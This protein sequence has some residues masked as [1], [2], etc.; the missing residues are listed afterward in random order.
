LLCI[1]LFFH[2]CSR[3]K[4]FVSPARILNHSGKHERA[5]ANIVLEKIV[6]EAQGFR[7]LGIV[8]ERLACSVLSLLAIFGCH[9]LFNQ[10]LVTAMDCAHKNLI[11][12]LGIHR[13]L[14]K[15][16]VLP[17]GGFSGVES[18]PLGFAMFVLAV[19]D[20]DLADAALV[21]AVHFF[22]ER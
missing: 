8:I 18:F 20:L 14:K 12:I 16:V 9:G 6:G 10:N 1:E 17:E 19:R 11:W 21:D 7:R 4:Q 2:P 3:L 22:V 15:F 13:V 5:V